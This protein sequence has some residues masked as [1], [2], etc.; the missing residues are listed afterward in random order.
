[1]NRNLWHKLSTFFEHGDLTPFAVI[2]SIA[3]Y[4]PVLASHGENVLVAWLVGTTIDL[5]HFRT[6]RRLFQVRGR[7]RVV[8][9]A[10]VAVLTTLMA[11]GYHLRFYGNDLLLAAPIPLGIA[12]LAQHAAAKGERDHANK[13]R[14]RVKAVIAIARRAQKKAQE[15]EM[16]YNRAQAQ[17][18]KLQEV[19][20]SLQKENERQQGQL[21]QAQAT[22]NSWHYLT[23]EQQALAQFKAGQ[24][25]AEQAAQLIGVKDTRTVQARAEKLNGV[26]K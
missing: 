22:L 26:H 9:H 3:H 24:I 25:T 8:G 18:N 16:N 23:H 4:G 15:F 10:F 12:I 5:I 20:V 1:M 6:V 14:N 7:K 11:L 13:W 21:L 17:I 2:I 19:R